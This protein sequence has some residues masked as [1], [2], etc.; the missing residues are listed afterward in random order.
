MSYRTERDYD[1]DD[2][3]I[4][5]L[6][7]IVRDHP[8]VDKQLCQCII[9]GCERDA[10]VRHKKD[11]KRF[12]AGPMCYECRLNTLI[13]CEVC[14]DYCG[15]VVLCANPEKKH[16]MCKSFARQGMYCG[17]YGCGYLMVVE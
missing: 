14:V 7:G 6:P 12:P 8:N 3:D 1:T 5:Q 15:E 17:R 11:K 2:D 4:D 16:A 13:K 10:L 9:Q